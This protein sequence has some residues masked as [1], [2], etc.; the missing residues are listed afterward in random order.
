MTTLTV[1]AELVGYLRTCLHSELGGAAD[2]I[3]STTLQPMRER[4]PKW[5]DD[6][7]A[8][9]DRTRALLDVIGWA[10]SSEPTPVEIDLTVHSAALLAGLTLAVVI[11][12]SDSAE[13]PTDQQRTDAAMRMYALRD[14]QAVAKLRYGGGA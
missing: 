6:G 11:A 10:D 13:E 12:E 7:L 3:S 5:Y 1:P 14:L 2:E 9:L 4:Y 8:R